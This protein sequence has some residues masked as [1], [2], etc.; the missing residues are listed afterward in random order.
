MTSR[1][2]CQDG[3][4]EEASSSCAARRYRARGS[5]GHAAI[6]KEVRSLRNDFDRFR[7]TSGEFTVRTPNENDKL[8]ALSK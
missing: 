2:T 6:L 3:T 5:P 4:K 1:T 7:K 8:S